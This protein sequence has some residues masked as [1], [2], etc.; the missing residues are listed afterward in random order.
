MIQYTPEQLREVYQ[1]WCATQG[2]VM[3]LEV[4]SVEQIQIAMS[5]RN[6]SWDEYCD[7]RDKL[8]KG[9]S[10]SRR[11]LKLQRENV[12]PIAEVITNDSHE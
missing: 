12:V 11:L 8:R 9:T 5:L 7:V 3:D 1:K 2:L 6:A 10:R 4:L